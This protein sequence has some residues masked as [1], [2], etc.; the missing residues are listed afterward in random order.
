MAA[1]SD[2]VA[3]TWIRPSI[4]WLVVDVGVGA[5]KEMSMLRCSIGT[6]GGDGDWAAAAVGAAAAMTA[7]ASVAA[8][9]G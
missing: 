3:I 1:P 7:M 4:Q 5:A 6:M 9:A 2:V 8:V